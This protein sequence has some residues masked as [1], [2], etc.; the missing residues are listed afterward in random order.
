MYLIPFKL[1]VSFTNLKIVYGI[2]VLFFSIEYERDR[3][4]NLSRFA[5]SLSLIGGEKSA[6]KI[7]IFFVLL[8][9]AMKYFLFLYYV[10]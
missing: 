9:L 6:D 4:F 2:A 5:L 10:D 7:I 3:I 8:Y 1:N